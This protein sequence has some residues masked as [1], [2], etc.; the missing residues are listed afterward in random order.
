MSD[1]VSIPGPKPRPNPIRA[2]KAL[3]KNSVTHHSIAGVKG[4]MTTIQA[5]IASS[6]MPVHW[7]SMILADVAV[8]GAQSGTLNAH[9]HV[10]AQGETIAHYHFRKFV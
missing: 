9:V 1:P 3:P 10:D 2:G 7:K 4:D 8:S 6:T 5:A